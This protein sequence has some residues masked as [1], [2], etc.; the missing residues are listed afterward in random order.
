MVDVLITPASGTV[1]LTDAS[2]VT[3]EHGADKL[4]ASGTALYWG[5]S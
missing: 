1:K 5:Q 2:G 3:N 4:W